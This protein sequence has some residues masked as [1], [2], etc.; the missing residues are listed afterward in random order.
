MKHIGYTPGARIVF[1][2]TFG[3][4]WN[5]HSHSLGKSGD[6]WSIELKGVSQVWLSVTSGFV[7]AA[8]ANG[9][10]RIF[11][12]RDDG[13]EDYATVDGWQVNQWQPAA[14][15]GDGR[16]AAW[17][18]PPLATTPHRI[19]WREI[20]QSKTDEAFRPYEHVKWLQFSNDGNLL[21]AAGGRSL[22]AWSMKSKESVATRQIP[23]DLRTSQLGENCRFLVCSADGRYVSIGMEDRCFLWEPGPG[24]LQFAMARRFKTA[25]FALD[26]RLLAFASGNRVEIWEINPSR[27]LRAY[28]W[29]IEQIHCLAFSPDGLTMAAGGVGGIVIWDLDDL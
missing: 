19:L 13:I 12:A 17:F 28:E 29:P 5:V 27:C 18:C 24:K 22:T 23:V 9:A 3:Y 11:R 16:Y 4:P 6:S 25:A 2:E 1:A 15:S 20:N 10:I 21:F 14:V 26:S 8:E 7:A